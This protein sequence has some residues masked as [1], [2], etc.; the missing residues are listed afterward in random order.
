M[1]NGVFV[2]PGDVLGYSEEF[3]PGEGAYEEDGNICA[4]TT[5]RV[6]IDM[7]ER[8]LTVTPE[9]DVPAVPKDGDIVVCK[10]IDIRPQVAVV[11]IVKIKGN[12]REIAGS[13]RGGV[14]IS[15]ARN[16]YVS[17]LSREF[18]AGD[19]ILAKILNTQRRPMQLS[20]ADKEL[21]VIKA[22]CSICN[23]PLSKEG[24]IL[25]CK[26]CRRSSQRKLST[27][28]GKGEI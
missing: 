15:Q 19:V 13:F 6:S 22:Y 26:E 1:E 27:E 8:K 17:D 14:H 3:L 16:A 23:L 20:T 7:K 11:E 4:A 2:V 21:G 12:D 9:T 24:N 5:G 18:S 28:F 25:K 10:I